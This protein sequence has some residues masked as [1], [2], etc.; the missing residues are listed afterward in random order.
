MKR[1]PMVA[2]A[3]GLTIV[4][5]IGGPVVAAIIEQQR[6]RLGKLVEEKDNVIT[7][8]TI[9]KQRAAA[10]SAR[11]RAEVDRW[12]GRTN[13]WTLWPP[14]PEQPPRRVLLD[15][16]YANRFKSIATKLAT[17]PSKNLQ[18][19]VGHL[20]LAML[21]DQTAH[22][23]EARKHYRA[24]AKRLRDLT[25]E[26][27]ADAASL[28]ALAKCHERLAAL[29]HT[30]S[31]EEAQD[32]LQ[33]ASDIYQELASI[34]GSG[35]EF[36]IKRMDVELRAAASGG[37]ENAPPHLSEATQISREFNT[38][39]PTDEVELYL[40]VCA[41]AGEQPIAKQLLQPARD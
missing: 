17:N 35:Q 20:G 31:E 11:L 15:D 26:N 14:R 21:S 13:P 7:R 12:E 9:E 32:H 36:R 24:A 2:T 6:W 22:T 3:A 8:Y 33:K 18:T 5:A 19:A 16:L 23:E 40:I 4:L 38:R 34:R 29:S 25:E 1:K 39:W 30:S 10:E 37:I 41:L 28:Q 27:P